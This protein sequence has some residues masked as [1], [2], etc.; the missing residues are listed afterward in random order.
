MIGHQSS[1]VSAV[2]PGDSVVT[3]VSQGL[4]TLKLGENL[5]PTAGAFEIIERAYRSGSMT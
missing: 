5:H 2:V 4:H 1:G 3:R